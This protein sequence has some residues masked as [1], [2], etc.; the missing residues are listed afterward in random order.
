M[1]Q[2]NFVKNNLQGR[3]TLFSSVIIILCL[4]LAGCIKSPNGLEI[5]TQFID[6]KE[7]WLEASPADVNIDSTALKN[8][9][10]R[11][12]QKSS[13]LSLLVV[14]NGFLVH[15]SYFNGNDKEQL[16]DIRS[17]TKSIVCALTGIALEEGY[18][19]SIDETLGDYL[20]PQMAALNSETEQIKIRHLLTMTAGFQWDEMSGPSYNNWVRSNKTINYVLEQPLTDTPG[21]IFTYNS[22]T[23]HILG[24]LLQEAVKMPLPDFAD[25]CLL[26]KIGISR[27]Q[28]EILE[29]GHAN[30]GAGLDLR[31]RDMAKF[32]QLYLQQGKNLQEQIIPASWIEKTTKPHFNRRSNYGA[33]KNHSYGH[34]W[35]TFDTQANAGYFAWGWGGQHI[36]NVPSRNLV[37]VTTTDFRNLGPDG[38]SDVMMRFVLEL[39]LD[40][41]L[42]GVN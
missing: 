15:E 12:S 9:D 20:S 22:G 18:I 25:K 39:I 17:V 27:R 16:N 34:L 2:F 30:G 40:Y 26:S 5:H 10:T 23:T 31:P 1:I 19:H 32:G 36:F 38:G 42:P 8:A 21:S 7:P 35:W 33:L 28:W 13:F 3:F 4:L 29:D 6:L 11:A 24:V 41:V 37:I 14:R